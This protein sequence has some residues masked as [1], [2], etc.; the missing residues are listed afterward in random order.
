MLDEIN[1]RPEFPTAKVNE[2]ISCLNSTDGEYKRLVG[3]EPRNK[4]IISD[5]K[6]N[7]LEKNKTDLNQARAANDSLRIDKFAKKEAGLKAKLDSLTLEIAISKEQSLVL[8]NVLKESYNKIITYFTEIEDSR[9][10]EFQRKLET[11]PV[12]N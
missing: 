5:I 10:N 12:E 7:L 3:I 1:R 11:L 8:K 4:A 6:A 2:Y 9:K